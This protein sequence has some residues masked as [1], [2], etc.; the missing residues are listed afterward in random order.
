M[1]HDGDAPVYVDPSEEAYTVARLADNTE[2]EVLEGGGDW[3]RVAYYNPSTYQ[4]ADGWVNAAYV[5]NLRT[6]LTPGPYYINLHDA[7]DVLDRPS[8]SGIL[9]GRIPEGE[10]LDV[11]AST[12][13]WVQIVFPNPN[14]TRGTGWVKRPYVVPYAAPIAQTPEPRVSADASSSPAVRYP[15]AVVTPAPT[16]NASSFADQY[17]PGTHTV[18]LN[19][20][21]PE[22]PV[23]LRKRPNEY[24][25]S[26]GE[27]YNGVVGEYL[28]YDVSGW[29]ET[30]IGSAVGYWP[31]EDVWVDAPP[32]AVPSAIPSA[33]VVELK[34]GSHLNLRE[35]PS[36]SAYTLESYDS[37]TELEIL[38]VADSWLHVRVNGVIGY[39]Y[40][41]Y[42][43]RIV[44]RYVDPRTIPQNP[45]FAGAVDSIEQDADLEILD[46]PAA[47]A[48]PTAAP[49][50]DDVIPTTRPT[51]VV[52]PKIALPPYAVISNPSGARLNLREQPNA[53]SRSLGLYNNGVCVTIDASYDGE[54]V[55][56]SIGTTSGYMALDYL[57]TQNIPDGAPKSYPSSIP[58]AR[59]VRTGSGSII[60][61]A[62]PNDISDQLGSFAPGTQA[63][64]LGVGQIWSQV[65]ISGKIGYVRNENLEY[66]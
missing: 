5:I 19:S 12:S 2:V 23:K 9:L 33:H 8:A 38:A 29:V 62:A 66:L 39:M 27:Y 6:H 30:R 54:W 57:D 53:D 18:T 65:V 59:L 21:N 16:D 20:K 32:G 60:M 28:S 40:G 13:E 31:V 58:R 63:I 15:I 48:T 34:V 56:V 11:V 42:V 4:R 41:Q 35:Y 64:V 17:P 43:T 24:A 47:Q 46:K 50:V 14:G 7:A 3:V 45:P 55:K 22:S 10:L 49:A 25:A 44:N 26:V 52:T 36:T 51:I 37:G 1:I 61:Y